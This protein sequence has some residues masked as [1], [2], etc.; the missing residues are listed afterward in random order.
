MNTAKIA[1]SVDE[2]IVEKL[3]RLVKKHIYPSRSRAIQL[4]IEEKLARL[5]RTR[6]ACECD[7]LDKKFEQTFADEGISQEIDEWPEY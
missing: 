2:S 5:N 6:L 3:D 1:I 4:A 7:K